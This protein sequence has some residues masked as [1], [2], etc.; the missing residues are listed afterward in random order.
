M[1]SADDEPRTDFSSES[2]SDS[3]FSSDGLVAL[4]TL[5]PLNLSIFRCEV[6]AGSD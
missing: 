1:S 4:V 3:D 6:E 2:A 5:L